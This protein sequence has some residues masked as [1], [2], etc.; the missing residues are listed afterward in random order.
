MNSS[1]R[2]R[3]RWRVA[4]AALVVACL[5]AW[6]G[7]DGGDPGVFLSGLS[8]PVGR[9]DPECGTLLWHAD[10]SVEGG[11]TWQYG[12]V[13]PPYYGAFAERY[14]GEWEVCAQVFGFGRLS[15]YPERLMDVYVWDDAEGNVPGDV[16]CLT[17]GVD[18]GPI[19][20]WGNISYHRVEIGPGCC[21][22]EVW[23]TGFWGD[24]PGALPG[25][26][27][28]ADL[29]GPGGGRP[30]TNVAPG[31]GYPSGWQ[32]VMVVWGPTQALF[33]GAEVIP[34]SR[35]RPRERLGEGSSHSTSDSG[36]GVVAST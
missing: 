16:L 10:G 24:W 30:V 22:G 35:R 33:L 26:L 27:V 8:T 14:E 5:V 2:T 19:A 32:D 34:A 4:G 36:W 31:V 9:P 29:D 3:R 11:Y 28:G 15:Y 12:G 6:S 25:W 20:N 23:W 17:T 7:A 1:S 13:V 21:T 18:P